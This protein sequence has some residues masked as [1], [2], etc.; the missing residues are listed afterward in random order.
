MFVEISKSL[1]VGELVD[2]YDK[3]NIDEFYYKDLRRKRGQEVVVMVNNQ[4]AL[5]MA[6]IW[7][8]F[9]VM[10]VYFDHKDEVRGP[11]FKT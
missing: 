8:K 4:N 1:Y 11:L 6:K 5:K 9:G 10:A 2:Y 3:C 7:G